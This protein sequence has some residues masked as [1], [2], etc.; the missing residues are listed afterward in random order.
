[1]RQTSARI[2]CDRL[3]LNRKSKDD[4]RMMSKDS[5][6]AS[7]NLKAG[8]NNLKNTVDYRQVSP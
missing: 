6:Y 5:R 1:M 7:G 2:G 4:C 8:V 3:I